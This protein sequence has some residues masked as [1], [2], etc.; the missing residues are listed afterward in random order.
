MTREEL[1]EATIDYLMTRMRG[2]ESV[3]PTWVMKQDRDIQKASRYMQMP[4]PSV[5]EAKKC[6]RSLR[7]RI[8]G[9]RR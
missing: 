5:L 4:S 2:G 7:D 6:M 8:K 3:G 9:G 1:I